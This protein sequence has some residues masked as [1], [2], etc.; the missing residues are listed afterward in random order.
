V[1]LSDEHIEEM[2]G[3]E[4]DYAQDLTA[5]DA[6]ILLA[7]CAAKEKADT[8][9]KQIDDAKRIGKLAK[10][11]PIFSDIG[12]SIEP[13]VNKFINIIETK[14]DLVKPMR[15]AAKMLTPPQKEI[16]FSMAAE[17]IMPD[18]VLSAVRKSILDKFVLS[19]N[20][21]NKVAQQ[22]MTETSQ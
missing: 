6:I 12:E 7:V 16:A 4:N 22:I 2:D 8:E 15:L 1:G 11:H 10:K 20:I 19:L 17:I 3:Y 21:D 5:N 13:A 18:G 9:K 14:A